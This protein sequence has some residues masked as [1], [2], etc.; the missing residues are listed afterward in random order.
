MVS[1]D[2]LLV[3]AWKLY[4]ASYLLDVVDGPAVAARHVD[5]NLTRLLLPYRLDE[6]WSVA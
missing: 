1:A 5:V 2:E 6:H 4:R 3:D